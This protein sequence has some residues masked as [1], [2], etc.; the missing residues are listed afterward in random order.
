ME[1]GLFFSK[2]YPPAS[3]VKT[4]NGTADRVLG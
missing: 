3:I 2:P 1:N 4:L